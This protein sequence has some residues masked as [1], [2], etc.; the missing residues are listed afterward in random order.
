M[1]KC[2]SNEPSNPQTE[3]GRSSVTPTQNTT[4][5]TALALSQ[6]LQNPDFRIEIA[7]SKIK[8]TPSPETPTLCDSTQSTFSALS[9]ISHARSYAPKVCCTRTQEPSDSCI[10]NSKPSPYT[11]TTQSSKW[12]QKENF[13]K[14]INVSFCVSSLGVQASR[15]PS[16]FVRQFSMMFETAMQ[17]SPKVAPI[18]RRKYG[19]LCFSFVLLGRTSASGR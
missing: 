12:L 3:W 18:I 6:G 8:A 7:P 9:H 13:Q 1:G 14:C 16:Q 15:S 19:H 5:Q 4:Y 11:S 10:C 2:R 17:L